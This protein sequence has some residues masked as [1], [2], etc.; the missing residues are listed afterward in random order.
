VPK[1][2]PLAI[3]GAAYVAA[4]WEE[5]DWR[6]LGRET[7]TSDLLSAQPRLYR[8][9]SFGDEDYPEAAQSALIAVL[10][11]G[12]DPSEGQ[13]G[14]MELMS[15]F[16]PDLPAW[17][18]QHAPYRIKRLFDAYIA[19]R[20][21]SEIPTVWVDSHY[22]TADQTMKPTKAQTPKPAITAQAP[23]S[24]TAT[25]AE[26]PVKEAPMSPRRE[27][28][29]LTS[30]SGTES[31][32]FI[33]HGHDENAMLRIA[34][35]V[36]SLTGINPISLAEEAGGGDT[37]IEKFER[38]GGAADY[39][40]VLL[41]GDDVGQTTVA[42]ENNEKPQPRARQNV[43]LELGYFIGK[44]TRAHVIVVDEGVERPS[45]I[46]GLSYVRTPATEG[47]SSQGVEAPG[48]TS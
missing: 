15:E 7:G 16:M 47:R 22:V 45:D 30:P 3:S 12:V 38:V 19:S 25:N 17:V 32:I 27:I 23:I 13:K 26:E 40:I 39:A 4:K 2:D 24:M 1:P 20:S 37:I 9:L 10:R 41:S 8:S 5:R 42:H 34:R 46:A 48:L 44:L 43:V 31:R 21:F 33:V 18:A 36:F 29:P 35:H 28:S 14:R 6:A 11:E